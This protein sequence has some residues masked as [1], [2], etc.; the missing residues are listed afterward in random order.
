MAL[1]SCANNKLLAQHIV[2]WKRE[3][4]SKSKLCVLSNIKKNT[5]E[6]HTVN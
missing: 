1:L 5:L 2:T 3:I 6:N 4:D